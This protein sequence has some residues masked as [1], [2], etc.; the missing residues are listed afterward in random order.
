MET[1]VTFTRWDM[2]FLGLAKY[3][4]TWSKDPSTKVG[5]VITDWENN[6]VSL[7]YNGFPKKVEDKPELYNNREEKYKRI[8][9]AEMNAILLAK[10]NLDRCSLYTYPFAPCSNCAKQIIQTGI[11]TVVAPKLDENDPLFERWQKDLLFAKELLNE[12]G[13]DLYL[14]DKSSI[15]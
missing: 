6:V 1:I 8:V 3:I 14:I 10:S 4:S 13:V 5:A 11:Y 2:K 9:H 15:L 12:G 7:G